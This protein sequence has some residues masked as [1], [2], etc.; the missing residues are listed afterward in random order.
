MKTFQ[1]VRGSYQY[2]ITIGDIAYGNDEIQSNPQLSVNGASDG[3][4]IGNVVV[5]TFTASVILKGD[6]PERNTLVALDCNGKKLGSWYIHDRTFKNGIL[7]FSADDILSFT[8]DTY[9]QPPEDYTDSETGT[10]YSFSRTVEAQLPLIESRMSRIESVSFP[11]PDS[12]VAALDVPYKSGMS[13]R[14]VLG[15]IASASC[16]NYCVTPQA[17]G[18]VPAIIKP[19]DS[20]L[21]LSADDYAD[22]T[23]GAT[24]SKIEQ[25]TV[26][27]NGTDIPVLVGNET[28]EDYGIIQKPAGTYKKYQ[29]LE[30]VNPIIPGATSNGVE[31]D[32]SGIPLL[33][34]GVGSFGTPF[35]CGKC[36]VDNIYPCYT[37]VK[38]DG[39]SQTFYASS[40]SYT[41][42]DSGIFASISG[43]GKAETD[44][45]YIGE[46][47]VKLN[48]KIGVDEQY[49][50]LKI[51]RNGTLK[52][53]DS[54]GNCMTEF[55][56]GQLIFF[57]NDS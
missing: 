39:Y 45:D 18:N 34:I 44:A 24:G 15:Y 17:T 37:M 54:D 28:L 7:S 57:S 52:S 47:A 20:I 3:Y 51:S 36:V 8:D 5:S 2:V 4:P 55:T 56:Q 25:I 43:D 22:L 53:S 30:V 32:V 35:S 31:Y 33:S 26:F 46:T 42:T 49:G 10:A 21:T 13:M 6:I 40:I 1:E 29:T 27:K 41:F 16:G 14:E 9:D 23:I 50:C 11:S 19:G 38:F 48:R 12:T